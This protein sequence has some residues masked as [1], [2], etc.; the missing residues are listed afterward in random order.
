MINKKEFD[1][2]LEEI[3]QIEN[4]IEEMKILNQFDE[5]SKYNDELEAI[6]EKA[7]NI[8]I[9][10]ENS[11]EGFDDISLD[12]LLDLIKLNS[13]V[14]YYVL[15]ANNIIAS[16]SENKI[17]AE[18]LKKIKK[19]WETLDADIKTWNQEAHNPLKEIEHNKQIGKIT[20]DIILYKLQIEAVIDFT[21]I[22]K[23]CKKDFLIN[24]IKEVLYEGAKEEQEDNIKRNLLINWAKKISERELY[25]YKLWQQILMIKN[26]RSRDDHIEIIGNILEKD[27]RKYVIDEQNVKKEKQLISEDEQDL[28]MYYDSG[29]IVE[30]IKNYFKLIKEK[31]LQNKMMLNWKTSNGPAFKSKL[32]DES[33]RYSKDYLDKHTI[34]NVKKLIIAT[35]GVAKYH[36]EKNAKFNEL[37]EIEF[38]T[39][40]ARAC[41]SLSPDKTYK[42]IGNDTFENC[43]KLQ[44]LNLGKI[45]MIGERAFK[46]CKNLSNI[47]F[48]PSLKH[49][50]EN[51]FMN[52][53]NIT[54]V[55]F[56]G[57]LNLFVLDRPQ[58]VLNCFKGTNLEEIIFPNI[59]FAFNFAITD[60]PSLKRILISNIPGIQIP[61]K[62]CKYRLGR[63]EGIVAFIGEKSLNLWKRKNNSI[64]FFELTNEDI[65]KYNIRKI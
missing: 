28:E 38:L 16:V 6:K 36:F 65:K 11:S 58:N 37:E 2:L 17:D 15:K 7:K 52:C 20:L 62:V 49:I 5:A 34:E 48:T 55:E 45:E 10:N 40:K 12:V 8:V 64:R 50:G 1:L 13:E 33:T 42:C 53:E 60:C 9:D 51:A 61:F 63:E 44:N 14:D 41:V 22:F 56:L 18:A 30:S 46:D 47:I 23:Y 26:I 21:E 27:D 29:S 31:T 43:E 25:N 39:E 59:D 4:K 3:F 32:V 19:L 24:A 35:D 54:R 57:E